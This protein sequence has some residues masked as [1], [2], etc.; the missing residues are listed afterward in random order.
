VMEIHPGDVIQGRVTDLCSFGAFVD[1][2]GLEGLLH[3]SELSWGHVHH[4]GDLLSPG[5]VLKLYVLDVDR[6][7]RRIR[8]SMKRLQ[9]DPWAS[10]EERYRVGQIVEGTVTQVAK[11]GAFV[12]IEEGVEGL[13]HVSRLSTGRSSSSQRPVKAGDRVTVRIIR[14]D[15][16]RRRMR[17]GWEP[18]EAQYVQT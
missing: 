9:P 4:P 7:K 18:T 15:G 17:L 5:Q 16:R 2:G 1:V 6:E 12:R 10:I 14:V 11:F 13:I 3:I 8:L